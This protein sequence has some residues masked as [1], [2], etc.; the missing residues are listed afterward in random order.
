MYINNTNAACR[1]DI[2]N[3]NPYP[4]SPNV[5]KTYGGGCVYPTEGVIIYDPLSI[6]KLTSDSMYYGYPSGFTVM[7]KGGN[8]Y[9]GQS[10]YVKLRFV[11]INNEA[12][13]SSLYFT[14]NGIT[15]YWMQGDPY[16]EVIGTN[17]TSS[18]TLYV[19]FNK[20]MYGFNE[21][22]P[23]WHNPNQVYHITYK[24]QF[25]D[26]F[27]NVMYETAV[28]KKIMY[29]NTSAINPF[30]MSQVFVHWGNY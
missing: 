15:N 2:M 7:K 19:T 26:A 27:N 14:H 24:I 5:Y 1:I 4:T 22:L 23:S 28:D 30:I 25:I 13:D 10:P 6:V 29:G 8:P 11:V 17:S 3:I 16:M 9:L 20:R 21:P 12:G 18:G